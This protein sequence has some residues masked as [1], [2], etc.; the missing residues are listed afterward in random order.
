MKQYPSRLKFKKNHRINSSNL[1]LL[2]NKNFFPL[3]GCYFIKL[4]ESGKLN[5][6]QIE[7]CR[8]SI[9]RS[10]RKEGNL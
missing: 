9:R 5:F 6:K 3:N 1:F 7:A 8:K 10:L 2:D 4:I